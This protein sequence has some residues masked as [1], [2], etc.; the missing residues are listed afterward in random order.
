VSGVQALALPDNRRKLAE[1]TDKCKAADEKAL[2]LLKELLR[3][4]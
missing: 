1:L 3:K 4:L 2:E